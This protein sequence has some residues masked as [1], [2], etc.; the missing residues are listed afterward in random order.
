MTELTG[1]MERDAVEASTTGNPQV[2]A[3]LESLEVL[4][5]L[6]VEEHVAVF[7]TAHAELRSAL[8]SAAPASSQG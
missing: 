8:S 6:P 3:V 5:E 1:P 4:P 7:E 2:D